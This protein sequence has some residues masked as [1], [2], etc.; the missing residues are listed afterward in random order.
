[1][2]HAW[3][4]DLDGTLADTDADIRLAWKS[5]MADLGLA[6]ANFERDFVAGP[7]IEEM[8]KKLF[9]AEYTDELGA[10]LRVKFGEHYDHDGFPLTREYPG[11]IE[12]VRE[13]KAAGDLVVI[14]TN[15]RY[16]GAKLM[17]AHF[18]WDKL[19]DGIY[20]GDMY[21]DDPT[22][23]RLS[24]S[25]LLMRIMRIYALEQQACTMVGDTA[26]DFNAA[27]ECSIASVGVRWGYGK[28]EELALAG[29]TVSTAAEI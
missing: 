15:K 7:P 1:M 12:R 4:F 2:R 20:A 25:G 17:A 3:F 9:P 8:A 27:R 13:L 19:F 5:A 14:A 6:A 10:R 28:R 21:R 23:G 26:S 29:R 18:G 11:V 16:T 24:K 22:I